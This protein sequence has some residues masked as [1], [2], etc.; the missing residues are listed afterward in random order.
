MRKKLLLSVFLVMAMTSLSAA[1]NYIKR[2][3]RGAWIATVSQIDWPSNAGT[4]LAIRRQQQNEMKTYLD[5]L[6]AANINA[7]YF[8]TRP[9]ADALYKSSYEPSS[10]YFTGQRGA[11]LTWDPLEF[12]VAECHKRGMECHA[13]VDA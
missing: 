2:E 10:S 11:R 4:S 8:Q 1:D 5:E 3:V 6:Q 7:I 9:M 12:V 13:W